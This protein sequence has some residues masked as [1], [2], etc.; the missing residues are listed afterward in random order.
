MSTVTSAASLAQELAAICGSEQV[1]EDRAALEQLAVDEVVPSV[2]VSPSS[3]EQIAAVLR[4]ASAR[5]LCVVPSGGFTAQQIGRVPE[6]IDILLRA[7]RLNEILHYDPGDLTVGVG[8][9]CTLA[10][11]QST[12]AERG[13]F[14]PVDPPQSET[15]T[16]GGLLAT[17]AHGPLRHGYGGLR[18]FCIGI[19]FVTG[20][21][22]VAKAGG[23]VV[24][25]VT[26]YDVMKLLIGSHGTLGVIA[27]A[28]FKVSPLPRQTRTFV[29]RFATLAEAIAFRDRISASP[30]TPM[31]LEV[32]SPGATEYLETHQAARD[33]DDYHP[34]QML[35]RETAWRVVLRATGSDAVLARYRRELGSAVSEE[36]GADEEMRFWQRF[37]NLAPAIRSR[38]QNAMILEMSVAPS[39]AQNAITAA[40]RAALDN[41][42]IPAITGRAGLGLFVIGFV[43]LSVDPPSAMQY[44]MAVSALRSAL[45]NDSALTVVSCPTEAKR[46]F[47]VWGS[48]VTDLDS[49]LAV[50]RA[51]D[52][53]SILN[54]GRHFVEGDA[55]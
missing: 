49:M 51:L 32:I 6:R 31:C 9:G 25:N 47:C 39:E 16:I 43:P 33:P 46:H 18:D 4:L 11:L 15:A 36:L 21:G 48:S 50:K 35:A 44:A 53:K 10:K 26:G 40:E 3:A 28:N 27:S 8:A 17:A 19:Q 2:M 5:E 24:K 13:Q 45:P 38:H 42:F 22:K 12:L 34:P 14:L 23:R 20:D 37:T 41:N 30:L 54:R 52:P 7:Q 55:R 29:A 1:R